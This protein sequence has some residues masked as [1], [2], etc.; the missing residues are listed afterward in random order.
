MD[1]ERSGDLRFSR[2]QSDDVQVQ[3]RPVRT[4]PGRTGVGSSA[5]M[6]AVIPPGWHGGRDPPLTSATK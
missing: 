2:R 5:G 1:L 6:T 3:R 4:G